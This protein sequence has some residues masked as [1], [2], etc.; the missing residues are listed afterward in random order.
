MKKL[1]LLISSAVVLSVNLQ[2]EEG[3]QSR[4]KNGV[5]HFDYKAE[6]L[7]PAEAKE[8]QQLELDL[9]AV[10]D[11][12]KEERTWENTVLAYMKAFDKYGEG[13]SMGSFLAY[14]SDD[15]QLRDAAT[16][17]DAVVSGYLIEVATRKDLYNAI[18]EYADTNPELGV[19]EA[20]VLKD[21]MIGFKNSGLTLPDD[22]L[23]KFR[24]LNKEKSVK[25][26]EYSKNLRE[27]KDPLYIT[28]DDLKGMDE[29]YIN[30]LKKTDDGK[31]IITLDYPD[32]IPFM[33]NSESD[34]AR[35]ELEFKFNTRGGEK[36]VKLLEDILDIRR[37]VAKLL[38]YKNIAEL[39][40]EN[41]MAKN[42]ENVFNFLESLAKDLKPLSKEEDKK[43]LAFKYEK[44]GKKSK[45]LAN[46]E[47][48]YW[49]NK[50]KKTNYE[51]DEEKIKEYFPSVFVV[52]Q[53]LNIFGD[54]FSVNFEPADIPVWHKDVKAFKVTEKGDGALVAYIYMDL[55]PREGKYT[56][57]ACFDLEDGYQ[58]DDDSYQP[59][60]TAI[61]ANMNPPFEDTPS[62][63]KHSEVETL[64]HEF[65]HVLHNALTKAKYAE[66]SGT[67][68]ARDFVEAPSQLFENWAW[69]PVVLKKM[70]KHYKTGEPLPDELIEKMIN[71]KKLGSA[72]AYLRQDLLASY[73]MTLH[74]KTR[75]TDPVK[76][77]FTL[78]KKIR[79]VSPT[80]GTM[81]PASFEH[82]VG[83]YDAG[84]YGYLWSEVIA[85]DFFSVFERE[86]IFNP[87]TGRRFRDTVLAVGGTYDEQETAEKFLGRKVSDEA[88][89]KSIGLSK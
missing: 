27:W 63:L 49:N 60:F 37:Q 33:L 2:G 42:P 54:L 3:M 39:K 68:V 4:F 45:Q 80:P 26:I 62:L 23:E 65:G 32:Y 59:P 6:Q 77:Y 1:L 71:A 74:T 43:I 83:G 41:R 86:G 88:F 56:H 21:M 19:P 46:W 52:E 81:M 35:K 75:F 13:F 61:V 29:N 15:K 51:I 12:P 72:G 78:A 55:Y 5:L 25:A 24:Q 7:A 76:L 64:F 82:I 53:M 50:Y 70:S 8:R 67:S 28:K 30:R 11:V 34:S 44:T 87:A 69:S 57:A 36:N 89:L 79:G 31:Y 38:G 14:V 17:L 40:L 73:D 84:Y 10:I 18:K 58:K 47:S 9:Q 48:G 20:R 22:K 85:Q 66:I 16:E